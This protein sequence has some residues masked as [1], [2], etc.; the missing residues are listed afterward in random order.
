MSRT[1]VLTVDKDPLVHRDV[2]C[3]NTNLQ[4]VM[5]VISTVLKGPLLNGLIHNI[6]GINTPSWCLKLPL[7]IV[8]YKSQ[9]HINY[10][11]M[12]E[13]F[14]DLSAKDDKKILYV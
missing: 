2:P 10:P 13:E 3:Y 4:T 6:S 12:V 1:G 14:C 8:L 7:M 9:Y 11:E 5:K